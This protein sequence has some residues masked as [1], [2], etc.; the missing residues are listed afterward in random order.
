MNKPTIRARLERYCYDVESN[1][2]PGKFYFVDLTANNGAG[3]CACRDFETRRQPAINRKEPI[4]TKPTTCIHLRRAL[5]QFLREVM[6]RLA[7]EEDRPKRRPISPGRFN[8]S[9][10]E[11]QTAQSRP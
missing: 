8:G 10:S 6:P 4:I 3:F 9:R 7:A 5:W 1:T 11:P 2:Q